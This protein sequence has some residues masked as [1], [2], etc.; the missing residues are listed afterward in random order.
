MKICCISAKAQHGKDTAA[1]LIKENLE[2]KGQR[3][4]I[5]H[6]ADLLKFICVKYFGWNEVKDEAGRTLLQYL[7]TDVVGAQNPA[8]WAE[9]IAGILKMLPNTWDYVL[10]PD[11]RYPIEVSTMKE[12]FETIVLRVERPN[13]DNGLTETQK[14]HASEVKMD[15]YKFDNVLLNDGSLEDFRVKVDAFVDNYLLG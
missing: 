5:T 15:D 14:Q 8:Y 9:F 7:G 13:F 1:K 2:Q 10:I 6:Y 3:V 4:L 11:C 12:Q